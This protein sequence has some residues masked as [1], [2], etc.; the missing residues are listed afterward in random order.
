MLR[1]FASTLAPVQ[2]RLDLSG[3]YLRVAPDALPL[4]LFVL[5]LPKLVHILKELLLS[6][7]TSRC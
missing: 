2:A 6:K 7:N 3:P 5:A 1:H 4:P